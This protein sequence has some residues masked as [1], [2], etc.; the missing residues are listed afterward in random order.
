MAPKSEL[1]VLHRQT[2]GPIK[3]LGSIKVA[4][5]ARH[6]TCTMGKIKFEL[7]VSFI[8]CC[9]EKDKTPPPTLEPMP[10]EA[11]VSDLSN[12]DYREGDKLTLQGQRVFIYVR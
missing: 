5:R 11:T 12:V 9:S 6:V 1:G 4:R 8:T 3:Q 10:K 2:P 7:I